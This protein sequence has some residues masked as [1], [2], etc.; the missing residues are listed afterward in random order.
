LRTLI[1]AAIVAADILAAAR[2]AAV[3]GVVL[4]AR[5]ALSLLCH[6]CSSKQPVREI[7]QA[8]SWGWVPQCFYGVNAIAEIWFYLFRIVVDL[9][10]AQ[11]DLPLPHS[12][13]A[14]LAGM[15]KCASRECWTRQD[16]HQSCRWWDSRA[17]IH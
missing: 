5:S 1:V 3:I 12:E 10:W 17:L 7:P 14:D 15:M 2:A 4:V 11:S 8:S 9:S 16:S 6:R 13:L